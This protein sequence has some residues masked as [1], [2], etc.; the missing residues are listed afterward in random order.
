MRALHTGS[1]AWVVHDVAVSMRARR[2][3]RAIYG[4]VL[5]IACMKGPLD[6]LA[7]GKDWDDRGRRAVEEQKI[8]DSKAREVNRVPLG[9]ARRADTDTVCRRCTPWHAEVAGVEE[10]DGARR[11]QEGSVAAQCGVGG[12]G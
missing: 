11:Q 9:A 8:A 7:V 4:L 3:Q 1:M 5:A 12:D 2:I 10:A 6:G